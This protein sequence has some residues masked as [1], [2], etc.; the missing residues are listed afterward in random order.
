MGRCAVEFLLRQIRETDY[1]AESR[2][3]GTSVTV[4]ESVAGVA[5][6]V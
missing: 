3:F 1:M 4:R 2:E 6:K 5:R